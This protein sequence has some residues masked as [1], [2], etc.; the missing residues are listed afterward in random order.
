ML[1]TAVRARIPVIKIK[2]KD[3]PNYIPMYL[4]EELGRKLPKFVSVGK[5]EPNKVYYTTEHIASKTYEEELKKKG[6]TV[7]K[8]N[9][10]KDSVGLDCGVLQLPESL[11][12]KY[13]DLQF[14]SGHQRIGGLFH[15]LNIETM[16]TIISLARGINTPVNYAALAKA[17]SMLVI[18]GIGLQR[19]DVTESDLKIY[20]PNKDIENWMGLDGQLFM[21]PEI[22]ELTPR[23][24]L[25]SGASGTGKTFT[26]KYLAYKMG[27]PLL[28]LDTSV[29]LDK[30][31]GQSEKYTKKMLAE[32]ESISPCILL[33]DEVEKLFN[34]KGSG[35]YGGD[36]VPK[37]LS[38]MLWWLQEHKSKVLTVMTTNNT[39]IIPKELIRPGRIDAVID[40]KPPTDAVGF[41]KNARD[42][43]G[44][45]ASLPKLVASL[46]GER[47]QATLIQAVKNAKKQEYLEEKLHGN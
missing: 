21:L 23:G 35:T 14:P 34:S 32:A 46:Q 9:A 29:I 13:L 8:V 4:A 20:S 11:R 19:I 27:M 42:A 30:F 26:T 17:K 1:R 2:I 18:Q 31:Q 3:T 39:D 40:F 16:G 22:S 47:T 28:L 36:S 7:I 33:I 45:Q 41:L 37:V 10:H 44:V 5:V 24:L 12:Q 43:M 6:S 15:G 38:L 25:F